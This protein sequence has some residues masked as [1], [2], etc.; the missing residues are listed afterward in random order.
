M[1]PELAV[2]NS[3]AAKRADFIMEVLGYYPTRK[4]KN[5]PGDI[6]PLYKIM[7]L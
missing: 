2:K 4:V 5:K 1:G 7:H 3:E 6:I